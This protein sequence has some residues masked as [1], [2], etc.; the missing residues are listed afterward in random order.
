MSFCDAQNGFDEYLSDTAM[1][2]KFTLNQGC[3]FRVDSLVYAQWV[4]K[5]FS[6]RSILKTD[7]RRS[8]PWD[9]LL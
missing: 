5:T 6:T 4:A 9:F 3:W 8:D 2:L 1:K 7:K